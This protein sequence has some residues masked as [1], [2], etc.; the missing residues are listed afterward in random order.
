[1]NKNNQSEGNQMA[2]VLHSLLLMPSWRTPFLATFTVCSAVFQKPASLYPSFGPAAP[3]VDVLLCGAEH[4]LSRLPSWSGW[5]VM[6]AGA[7]DVVGWREV[8]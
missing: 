2:H 4:Y 8:M 6:G 3:G 7:R 5:K 1:M